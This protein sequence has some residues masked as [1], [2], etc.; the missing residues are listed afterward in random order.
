MWFYIGHLNGN[1]YATD[2]QQD[3]ADLYCEV[4]GDSDWEIGE[5]ESG[6]ELKEYILVDDFFGEY[7]ESYLD[8]VVKEYFG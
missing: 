2:E 5:F 7:E 1:I 4:C 8:E 6:E 3:F